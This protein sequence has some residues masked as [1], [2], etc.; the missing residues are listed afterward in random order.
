MEQKLYPCNE[1]GTKV[2][3]R[4]KGLCSFCR[5]KQKGSPLKR[6]V[7]RQTIKNKLKK[8]KK[9]EILKN[10]FEFHLENIKKRPYCDNCGCKLSCNI[11]NVAHILPKR[12]SANPE[13]M[14]NIDNCLYLCASVNGEIG[15]H[16]KFDK[17][18]ATYK[19]YLM[20]C[21]EKAVEKY[22]TFKDKV[23]YNKYVSNFE[24]YLNENVPL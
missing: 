20:P 6:Y 23:R 22:L 17:I 14:D 12:A 3:I 24:D 18:Q 15:C 9:A 21:W 11:A 10:F 5:Y 7:L 8:Q 2:K 13:V 16:D 19:V 1:C 4:S